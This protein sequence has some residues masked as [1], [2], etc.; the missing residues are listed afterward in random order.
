MDRKGPPEAL[1]PGDLKVR[2][3]SISSRAGG[4]GDQQEGPCVPSSPLLT[5]VCA[6]LSRRP[7]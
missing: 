7:S 2:G 4:P 1:S 5:Q 6:Q 3:T